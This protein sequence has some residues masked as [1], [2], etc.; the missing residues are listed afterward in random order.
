MGSGGKPQQ[1]WLRR[2]QLLLSFQNNFMRQGLFVGLVTI[3]L[4]YLSESGPPAANQKIVATDY[5]VSTGGPATNAAVTFSH[6]GSDAKLLGVIGSH[7]I[8]QWVQADLEAHEI[9]LVDLDPDR[10]Q[11]P[12]VSSII[13][14]QATAERAIISLNAAKAQAQPEQIPPQVWEGLLGI[15]IVLIDGHQMAVG[16]AIAKR[17]KA[18]D[19]PVV[20]DGG[21]WKPGFETVLP[22]VDYAICSQD[23]YPPSCET[24]QQVLAYLVEMGIPQIAITQQNQPIEYLKAGQLGQVEVPK[25]KPVDTA[26]AGD[27][28]H[29]AFCHFILDYDFEQALA[30]AA[31]VASYACEW[32]GTRSWLEHYPHQS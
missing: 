25:I 23:F 22:F 5:T 4:V 30:K 15:D 29:G 1:Q 8:Q 7:P 18:K 10:P 6:L 21:S 2:F 17:A 13:V 32:F 3:D 28:F 11:P 12:P 14:N 19:I 16:A 27:I 26:G 31:Q 20:I 24:P 9:T